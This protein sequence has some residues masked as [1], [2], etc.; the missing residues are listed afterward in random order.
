MLT[1]ETVAIPCEDEDLRPGQ[2]MVG[3][4]IASI[5]DRGRPSRRRGGRSL[6]RSRASMF[7]RRQGCDDLRSF[8]SRALVACIMRPRQIPKVVRSHR[9]PEMRSAVNEEFLAICN[10]EHVMGA[11]LT[12]RHQGLGER[13]HQVMMAQHTV[14]MHAVCHAFPSTTSEALSLRQSSMMSRNS[15]E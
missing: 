12:P 14:L 13:G 1:T 5:A 3:G 11:A 4:I 2:D 8:F 15:V 6:S 7:E 9:G 10:V